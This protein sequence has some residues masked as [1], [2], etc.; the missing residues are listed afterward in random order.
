MARGS[1]ARLRAPVYRRT[2]TRQAFLCALDLSVVFGVYNCVLLIFFAPSAVLCSSA[3]Q[4]DYPMRPLQVASGLAS[5]F[6]VLICLPFPAAAQAGAP[7]SIQI[8]MPGGGLP[9]RAIRFELTRDDG[10]IETLF[11]DTKGK[12][13][14]TG[15]LVRDADYIVRVE[16][17][18]RS[19]TATVVTFRTFRNIVTYVPVFLNPI[20]ST[21]RTAAAVNVVDLNVPAEAQTYYQKAMDALAKSDTKTAISNLQS[22]VRSH[23]H[24]VRALNDLGVIYLQSGQLDQAATTFRQ[25]IKINESFVYPRLNLGVVLNRQGKFAEASQVLG[26][27]FEESALP[28]ARLPYGEALT[29]TGKLNEAEKIFRAVAEDLNTADAVR[30]QAHFRLGALLNKQNRF[31]DAV[32]QFEQSIKLEPKMIMAHLQ[33][34]GALLQLKR[35]AEAERELLLAYELG[36]PSAGAAQFLLG[37]VFHAQGKYELAVK[38]FEQY[39]KDVPNAP[40]AAQVKEAI[41]KI[42]AALKD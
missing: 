36:G 6:V 21:T 33:L 27:L 3:F 18:R 2:P 41:E 14:I 10:R 25:A 13:Q 4:F 9:D 42:K 1:Q 23:P 31:S 39:L 35:F 15:D 28:L 11:T 16:G 30:A 37:E 24:Y 29:E 38:A 40:N 7:S 12:F 22:A 20:G 19:F 26:R 8:F 34:G 32:P 17:D 5:I